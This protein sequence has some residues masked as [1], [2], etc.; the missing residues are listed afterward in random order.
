MVLNL[1]DGQ[2][3]RRE[4]HENWP[5]AFE[6]YQETLEIMKQY[7]QVVKQLDNLWPAFETEEQF[8]ASQ[9]Y[10]ECSNNKRGKIISY[11]ASLKAKP[12]LDHAKC[13]EVA[14]HVKR[15]FVHSQDETRIAEHEMNNDLI[16]PNLNHFLK[17]DLNMNNEDILE[18]VSTFKFESDS[19]LPDS[20]Q[21][22]LSEYCF[23]DLNTYCLWRQEYIYFLV[24]W[25]LFSYKIM[26]SATI[27]KTW[28]L[29][30]TY[31]KHYRRLIA[32]IQ[33]FQQG[34]TKIPFYNVD[35]H[36]EE[37]SSSLAC[38]KLL[39]NSEPSPEVWETPST[40]FEKPRWQS[41]NLYNL[42]A[43]MLTSKKHSGCLE[44][45]VNLKVMK[46]KN[47]L[48]RFR[49][50]Q[51]LRKHRGAHQHWRNWYEYMP[52]EEVEEHSSEED[53][54]SMSDESEDEVNENRHPPRE[55]VANQLRDSSEESSEGKSDSEFEASDQLDSSHSS[56]RMGGLFF[57]KNTHSEA[58][59][60]EPGLNGLVHG[61]FYKDILTGDNINLDDL[62]DC[63]MADVDLLHREE[64]NDVNFET[65]LQKFNNSAKT[66][67]CW[68]EKFSLKGCDRDRLL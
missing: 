62:A 16:H 24:L 67:Y 40:R 11:L 18:V 52:E 15:S 8:R 29:H 10:V 63:A 42:V 58:F 51:A 43:V 5:K 19:V 33:A 27:E 49:A 48:A 66:E 54:D 21:H 31:T 64:A 36:Y 12:R 20:F 50:R 13:E 9:S 22:N 38:Y 23:I 46:H 41:I 28:K 30:M 2:I 7:S 1:I 37:Y 53:G 60:E 3:D 17:N 47:N 44:D 6:D 39:Y 25:A 61:G 68:D 35:E 4:P 59:F 65:D 32:K 14:N 26:P 56:L 57:L 45:E 55:S 34:E